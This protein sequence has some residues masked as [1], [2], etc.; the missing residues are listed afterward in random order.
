MTKSEPTIHRRPTS[1]RIQVEDELRRGIIFGQFLPG[2]RLVERELCELFSVGRTSVRE[3]L[4]QMEAEGMVKSV[5]HRGPIVATINA[6]EARQIYELRALLEGYCGQEFI[7]RATQSQVTEL[8]KN[9]ESYAKAAA[10]NSQKLMF[11]AKRKF[12]QTLI[13]GA[14]NVQ[15]E[16]ILIPL[17]NR[18]A[19]LRMMSMSNPLRLPQT[20]AELNETVAAIEA[21][22][23]VR[24]QDACRRHVQNAARVVIAMLAQEKG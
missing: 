6:E 21:R 17:Q 5:P 13:Q 10:A 18:T 9:C 23:P 8:R 15:I 19:R 4:R 11:T 1:L 7:Q 2:T 24:A 14:E 16:R 12:Y 22:D 3:A 20:V